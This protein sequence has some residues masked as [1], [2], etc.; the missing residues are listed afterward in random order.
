MDAD[1][2]VKV[3]NERMAREL[4]W[5]GQQDFVRQSLRDWTVDGKVAG[6][7]RGA[8]GF[9]FATVQGAGHMVRWSWSHFPEPK[10]DGSYQVPFDKPKESL[11]LVQ[12]WLAGLDL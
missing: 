6:I 7:T 9:T 2:T 12:R 11:E 10:S 5:T 3:G 4:E 8:N 1:V